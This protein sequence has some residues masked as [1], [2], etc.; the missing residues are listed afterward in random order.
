MLYRPKSQSLN[1]FC[2]WKNFVGISK[3]TS[4]I[5][6]ENFPVRLRINHTVH[7]YKV[8]I[9]IRDYILINFCTSTNTTGFHTRLCSRIIFL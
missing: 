4:W 9:V 2:F 5:E 6:I 8:C 3:F 7:S 1:H